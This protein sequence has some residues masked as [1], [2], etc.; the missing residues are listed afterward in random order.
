MTAA[1]LPFRAVIGGRLSTT[2]PT[3][4]PANDGRDHANDNREPDDAA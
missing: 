3:P 1:L 2:L 4:S